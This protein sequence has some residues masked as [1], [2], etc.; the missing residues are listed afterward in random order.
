MA[1]T[2]ILYFS[3]SDFELAGM[4]M[5][6]DYDTPKVMSN[7]CTKYEFPVILQNKVIAWTKI[8]YFF[9]NDF[10]LAAIMTFD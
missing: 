3:A 9:A 2:I 7:L 4:T 10:E 6:Q 5:D 1:L 8:L